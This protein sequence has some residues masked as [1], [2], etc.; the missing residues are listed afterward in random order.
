MGGRNRGQVIVMFTLALFVLVG[1]VALGI[2]VGYMYSVK[3]DLQRSADAGALAGAYAF[4]DGGW[5][6]GPI[7]AALK[8][9]VGAISPRGTPWVRRRWTTE[10]SLSHTPQ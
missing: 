9:R 10:Q 3:N 7:P 1:F 2:D 4:H 6:P 8:T 5:V